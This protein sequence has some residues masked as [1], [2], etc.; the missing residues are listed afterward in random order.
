MYIYYCWI[1][2]L[3]PTY[4]D[5]IIAGLAKRGYMVGPAAADGTIC[6]V[7]DKC[8]S[9]LIALSVYKADPETKAVKVY[10][11]VSAVLKEMNA[12]Y[13]SVIISLSHEATWVGSNF[14]LP[15]KKEPPPPPPDK[16]TNV[17]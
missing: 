10:D 17:N 6:S 4:Q 7:Q 12:K 3:L 5:D 2:A 16:K 14:P 15:S 1:T 11:D 8:P 13:Y 9:A